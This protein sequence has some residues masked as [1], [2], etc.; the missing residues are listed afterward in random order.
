MPID[1]RDIGYSKAQFTILL[2]YIFIIMCTTMRTNRT[3]WDE[4]HHI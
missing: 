1:E 3:F 2:H 4:G